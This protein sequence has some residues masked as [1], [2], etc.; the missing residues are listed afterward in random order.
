[1][2]FVTVGTHPGQFDRLIKRIDEIAPE[3]NEKI[4]IQ[5]GFTKYK[6]KNVEYFDF[7]DDIKPYFKEARLIISQAATSVL[8]LVFSYD[9]ALILVPRRKKYREHINDHQVEFAEY[10]SAKTGV[11]TVLEMEEL[12]PELL[13]SYKKKAKVTKDGINKLQDAIIKIIEESNG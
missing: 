1:M 2:I 5:T 10:F 9:K 6:P 4:V 3:I 12:T 13:K 7:T 8:E 11:K